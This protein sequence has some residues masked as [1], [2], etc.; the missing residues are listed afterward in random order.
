MA[1]GFTGGQNEEGD[2]LNSLFRETKNLLVLFSNIVKQNVN[3][4]VLYF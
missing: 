1:S 3:S 2:K 4:V